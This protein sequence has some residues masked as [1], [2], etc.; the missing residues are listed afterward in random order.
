MRAD[1]RGAAAQIARLEQRRG[2]AAG[3]GDKIRVGDIT[4]A[5]R[6]GQAP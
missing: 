6:V 1:Q 2:A 5:I 4:R 3:Q